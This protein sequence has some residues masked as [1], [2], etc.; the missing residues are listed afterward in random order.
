MSR[1]RQLQV[2][3]MIGLDSDSDSAPFRHARHADIHVGC[4]LI[5]GD[6]IADFTPS[7]NP[8]PTLSVL[9]SSFRPRQP[10]IRI[11]MNAALGCRYFVSTRS[12]VSML[13]RC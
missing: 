11:I 7:S 1:P 9:I 8:N 6:F 3:G 5:L 12:T 2:T 13:I 4:T 10:A